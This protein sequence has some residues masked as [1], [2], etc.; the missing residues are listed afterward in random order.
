MSVPRPTSSAA[1][2]VHEAPEYVGA[3]LSYLLDEYS[4]VYWNVFQEECPLTAG[5]VYGIGRSD[6]NAILSVPGLLAR[7]YWWGDDLDPRAQEA[8]WEF[9]GVAFTWYKHPLRGLETNVQQGPEEWTAWFVRC[10][11]M[12]RTADIW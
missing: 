4:R 10:V 8:N 12:I 5:G 1:L 6:K 9:D 3:L 11:Q 2:C 7:S